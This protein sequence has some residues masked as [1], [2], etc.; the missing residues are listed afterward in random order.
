VELGDVGVRRTRLSGPWTVDGRP[1]EV[2]G[3]W[4]DAGI[5]KNLPGPF[6][7]LTTFEVPE[8]A[9]TDRLWLRF[10]AVSYACTVF[11]DGM[12]V[13][14]HVG[15]WDAFAVEI[16]SAVRGGEVSELRVRVEKPASLTAGPDSSTVPGRY[17][18]RETLAGFLPYV[19]GH[20]HGGIWQD[21][22]LEVS[23]ADVFGDVTAWGTPR[24]DL[25][26]HAGVSAP[27]AVR[28]S[29]TDPSGHLVLEEERRADTHAVFELTVPAA[30]AWSPDRPDL[31]TVRLDYEGDRARDVRVVRVGLR[32]LTTE[33]AGLRLNG[34]PLYPRMV[35]SWGWYPDLLHPAPSPDRV[36]ADLVQLRRLG[37]NGVKLCL[38]FPPAY[39]FDIADELGMLLWVELPMWLPE[40]SDHFRTQLR[41]E[42]DRLVR[43]ARDHPSVLLYTLGC[44]LG[45][46]V[47]ADVLAPLY[48]DV[49]AL[50]R[51]A[52]VCDNSGSG[53]AYGGL[54]TSYADFYDHHL[55]CEPQHFRET[56]EH[57]A[58]GWRASKPWLF[59]EFCDLDT[60]R[61]PGRVT[62]GTGP[63][64]L[65]RDPAVNPQGARWQYDV[66][67]HE[68]R[69]RRNGLWDRGPE[70][71]AHSRR[72]A[73]LHRKVTLEAVRLRADTS[74]YVVTGERDTPISTAGLWDDHGELKVDEDAFRAF[75]DD[76]VLCLGWDR[77][78]VWL[79]G[80]DR[81]AFGDPWCHEAGGTVRP[82]LVLA[83]H[84]THTG[85]VTVDWTVAFDGDEPFVQGH[86][87]SGR[88]AAAGSV[89]ALCAA[90]FVVPPIERPRTA[91]LRARATIG[92]DGGGDTT[93]T[94]NTWRFW[95]FPTAP[96]AAL[97]P[98]I[99]DDPNARFGDLHSLAGLV[100]SPGDAEP[101][102]STSGSVVLA[103]RWTSTLERR[104]R[105]GGRAVLLADE[106]SD[107]PVGLVP[108]PFWRESVKV[109]EP[110]GAWG[111]FPHEGWAD[112]QFAGCAPDLAM[113]VGADSA[114]RPILRRLD[115][116]TAQVHDY[117]TEL[118][119]GSG[120]L[121]VSTLRFDGGRGDQPRGLARNTGASY[122]LSRWVRYLQTDET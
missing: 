87:G 78:R 34:Q 120:R 51:D 122:L 39:Y 69:L 68:E 110:H 43:A 108:M 81:P 32:E 76:V 22:E 119:W 54:L 64:W 38:W 105:G 49:K 92:P 6:D 41:A 55:Y 114:A 90:E 15:M 104:V 102:A 88:P 71:E 7:Y 80:G 20:V 101:A 77:R 63:W 99:L 35:L 11:V 8:L 5:A 28:L 97:D 82:H 89:R 67:E 94:T 17:P 53:E 10:G 44:E 113:D 62:D 111:D 103:T 14:Q 57:F 107:S 24:G 13:G 2:P 91:L 83:H 74:G 29:L 42:T 46:T 100:G 19:W 21:V 47:G 95:F 25:T 65:S 36:R 75:N 109:F 70:L 121:I 18:T 33:G 16:T 56:V 60:F 93:S 50:A 59:G 31:Y 1:V 73:L 96:W 12:E 58:P 86:A 45:S 9:A 66:Q 61:D 115:T 85:S 4:E 37:F 112:L 79:A 48:A 40:P 3:C 106:C 72:Q 117:A 23:G 84:G 52:L 116:R 26:V 27:G 30:R 118:E 98:L